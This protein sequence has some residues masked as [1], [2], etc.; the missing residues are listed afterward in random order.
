MHGILNVITVI[1]SF[2]GTLF[3]MLPI[4]G[5]LWEKVAFGFDKINVAV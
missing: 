3:T 1:T 2:S 5:G 4:I